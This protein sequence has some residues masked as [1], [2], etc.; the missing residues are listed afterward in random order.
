MTAAV[1]TI[2]T[3][4]DP[5]EL[6]RLAGN[7]WPQLPADLND[8]GPA[9]PYPVTAFP[10]IARNAIWEYQAFGQQPMAM[11]ASS[12]LA[13]MA[14]AAQP[15][16]NVAR[17]RHLVGPISLNLMVFGESG[18]RKTAA[19]H[20]F[21]RAARQWQEEQRE[22][23]RP[24]HLKSVAMAKAHAARVDSIK[25]K[26]TAEAAKDST[27]SEAECK[28]LEE[29]LVSL[30]QNPVYVRP[31][32]TLTY[33]DATPAALQ[34]AIATGWPSCGL[35][36]DEAGA[37]IGS[38]GMGEDTATGLLSLLNILWD[39]RSYHPTRKQAATAELKGRR[40]SAFLM[41][42]PH[43]FATLIDR[44]A[45]SIGFVARFL[46]SA[47]KSTMGTRLYVEPPNDWQ[48]LEAFDR[49][50][51]RLLDQPLPIDTSGSDQ[52]HQMTLT[53]PV[54]TLDAGAKLAFVEYHNEVERELGTFGELGNVRDI[55]AKSAENA[56]RIATVFQVFDQGAAGERVA[57]SF[58]LAGIEVA[59]WH[60][61]EARRL[62]HEIA[63][64]Q[65][66]AD[67]RE[68]TEWLR[69]KAREL[70]DAKGEPLI[71]TQGEIALRDILRLGPNPVRDTARRDAAL[72]VLEDANHLRHCDSG[73]Q[74][75]VQLHP[76]L[77]NP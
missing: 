16:A 28:R 22:E 35:F 1:Q 5:D 69:I 27:E 32:P 51:L 15:L 46:L 20:Q 44:G 49:A 2:P 62:F 33:E 11:V 75:R 14:L 54:M 24:E 57:Q 53:P 40:V 9:I 6:E 38:H 37:F 19:D 63:A 48:E 13:Q 72:E 67:A 17:N 25:K 76:K 61:H 65:N 74:K 31:L 10:A 21:G 47:P 41:L 18:E 64:P 77:L 50:I 73:R 3:H 23:R 45:R 56:C 52:G 68:L 43:L 30:Q 29:R 8:V 4:L 39:G 7:D 58:M 59:R 12:A 42:Q 71:N 55:A 66:I 60:L 34:Y 36:S 70:T 26:L